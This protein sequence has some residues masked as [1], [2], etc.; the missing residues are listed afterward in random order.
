MIGNY[1]VVGRCGEWPTRIARAQCGLWDV[2]VG[3]KHVDPLVLG[4]RA[5]QPTMGKSVLFAA[6]DSYVEIFEGVG[7]EF[8][9]HFGFYL[10]A[11]ADLGDLIAEEGGLEGG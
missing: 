2:V 11:A 9:R 10:E 3:Q 4:R 1:I 5:A 6:A 8:Y 7:G